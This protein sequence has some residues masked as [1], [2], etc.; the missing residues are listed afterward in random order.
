VRQNSKNF[1]QKKTATPI[2]RIGC[3]RP[4]EAGPLRFFLKKKTTFGA[5][6]PKVRKVRKD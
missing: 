3:G 5:N 1:E 2:R 4:W 6:A